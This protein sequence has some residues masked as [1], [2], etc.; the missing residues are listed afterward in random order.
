[1]PVSVSQRS[2]EWLPGL[3][4]RYNLDPQ[5]SIRAAWWNSVVRANFSQLAPGI[6]L[7]SPTEAVIGNPNLKPLRSRNLDLGIERMLAGGGV[8]SVYLF[9]KD[10]K[11]FTY[12]TNLA[13]T[14]AWTGYTTATSYANGD[15]AAVRGAELAY[16]QPL[17]QL[18]GLL[19]GL[20]VGANAT[21]STSSATLSRFDR[22]ANAVL[23]RD[24]RLPGHSKTVLNLM[25]GY[26]AGP[27]S[28]RLALNQK[29][30]YL[31]ELGP[32]LLSAAQERW[33]DRQRQIDFSFA[34]QLDKRWQL[35]AEALNLNNEK[36]YVYQGSRAFNTQ[37]EQYGRTV[38]LTLKATAF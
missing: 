5:T 12:T 2:S 25:L 19:S 22:S 16:S 18:P 37:F 34:Y 28:T 29:S 20:I 24:V 36:Y 23:S 17:R 35:V 27:I 9:D 14:G 13:G 3:H 7:A 1:M 30:A 8:A 32:D 15:K 38:K 4:S 21:F 33:V 10:I 26:E 31:L 6:S 11:D